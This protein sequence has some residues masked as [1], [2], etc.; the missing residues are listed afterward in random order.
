MNLLAA[1]SGVLII[2]SLAFVYAGVTKRSSLPLYASLTTLFLGFALLSGELIP[3]GA[4]ST[5]TQIV[6]LAT[7][8]FFLFHEARLHLTKS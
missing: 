4:I 2:G 1:G 5:A 6:F 7:S 3:P 8:A